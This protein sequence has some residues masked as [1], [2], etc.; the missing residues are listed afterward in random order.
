VTPVINHFKSKSG[1]GSGLNADQGDGQGN[2]NLDRVNQAKALVQFINTT[3]IPATGDQDVIILGDLNAYFEEDPIDV[4]RAAGFVSLF[5]PESYSYVFD[6]QSGSLDHALVTPGLATQFTAGGKWHI[7]A[8]EPIFLDYN[9]EFKNPAQITSLY[10]PDPF[11]SS[12]HD[13]VLVGL[14]LFT[15]TV[16][17]DED[18]KTVSESAGNYTVN[19]TLSEPTYQATTLTIALATQGASAGDFST[20][21]VATENKITLSIPAGS[22]SASFTLNILEDRLDE[23]EEKITFT[24]DELSSGL[25]K[26]IVVATII[27]IEDND[28][29]VVMFAQS[30]ATQNEG[31]PAYT[32]TLQTDIAPAVNLTVPV[33]ISSAR[34]VRY[35]ERRD[36]VTNPDGSAGTITVTIPAGGMHGNFTVTPLADDDNE[37]A[38]ENVV[39]SLQSGNNYMLGGQTVFTFTI[40]DVKKNASVREMMISLWP[41]PTSGMVN[42]I[43]KL[44]NE[45]IAVTLRSPEGE[46]VFTGAGTAADMSRQISNT[47]LRRRGGLYHLQMIAGDEMISTRILK[48]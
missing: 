44:Q 37:R 15:P 39:F 8:D 6:K 46:V 22:T 4:L 34:D 20:A 12:D 26:G 23:L 47:L 9:T 10:A 18:A 1:T 16:S 45:T 27:T 30:A 2:F 41:N 35:G 42:I 17:F 33:T 24:I 25:K 13:P 7:N 32:V 48:F 29:P 3:V 11:R 5:G 40:L 28:M 31:S 21:P 38:P 19:L 43:T 36:Y 14:R